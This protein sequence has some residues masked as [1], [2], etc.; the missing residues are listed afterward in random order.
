MKKLVNVFQ[1]ARGMADLTLKP[2]SVFVRKIGSVMIVHLDYVALIVGIMADAK[3]QSVFVLRDG[4]VFDVNHK[5][6]ILD[7][8]FMG[9]AKMVL[10]CVCQDGMEN[11]ALLKDVRM[12]ADPRQNQ[13]PVDMGNVKEPLVL[14]LMLMVIGGRVSVMMGGKE[15]TVA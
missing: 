2:S 1:T 12:N 4:L 10:A 14:V 15:K 8:A 11:T 6:A 13:V 9:S 7:A 5:T 3:I